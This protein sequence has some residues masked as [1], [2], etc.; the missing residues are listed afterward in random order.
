M[1]K[2]I[3]LPLLFILLF[4][5][6]GY[7]Q[8]NFSNEQEEFYQKAM[9]QIN[10]RHVNWI[11]ANAPKIN[12]ENMSETEVRSMASRY[13]ASGNIQ[14]ADIDAMVFLVLMQAGKSAQE[15]LKAIMANVK[16]INQ[17]KNEFREA[18]EKLNTGNTVT[19]LQL[20]SFKLLLGKERR[21]ITKADSTKTVRTKVNTTPVAK[22][23][24]DNTRM[25]IKSKLDSM[26]E[27]GEMESL[28][29]QMA[30]ERQS[31]IMST[32][33]NIMKKISNTQNA[34]IQNLK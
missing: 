5:L 22:T 14:G 12:K 4:S 1:K 8:E 9:R 27:M 21:V 17:Q 25:Q 18:N 16:S 13:A 30:M 33:S 20:D 29:L 3:L 28:R 24:L 31:K 15:D 26:S 23:E 19:R 10:V 34:I 2:L 32:L 7:S 6:A 11:K